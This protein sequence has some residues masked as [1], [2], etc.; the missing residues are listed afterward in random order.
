MNLLP[1]GSLPALKPRQFVPPQL[2]LGDW[3]QLAPLF[4]QLEARGA[5]ADAMYAAL[6]KHYEGS[7][8]RVVSFSNRMVIID[9]SSDELRCEVA[10]H[11][12]WADLFR[13]EPAADVAPA[14]AVRADAEADSDE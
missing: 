13:I 10:E 14:E 8:P 2:D 12:G 7:V 4:E 11:R 3:T 1:F 5:A 9:D 6:N